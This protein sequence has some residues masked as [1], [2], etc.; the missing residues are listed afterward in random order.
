MTL[1][2]CLGESSFFSRDQNVQHPTGNVGPL[3][4]A[5]ANGRPKRFLGNNFRQN[6]MSIRIIES[7][8]SSRQT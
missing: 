3:I 2:I 7:T 6:D 1:D 5:L 4:V 8:T